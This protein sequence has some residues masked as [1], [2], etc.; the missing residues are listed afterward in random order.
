MCTDS[1]LYNISHFLFLFVNI[2]YYNSWNYVADLISSIPICF[3]WLYGSIL[4]CNPNNNFLFSGYIQVP[5]LDPKAPPDLATNSYWYFDQAY[6]SFN[7]KSTERDILWNQSE[8]CFFYLHWYYIRI[9]GVELDPVILIIIISF[10][11][12]TTS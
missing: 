6:R 3:L 12:Y 10:S 7:V 2:F 5:S 4:C 11:Q 9:T 8:F 1:P